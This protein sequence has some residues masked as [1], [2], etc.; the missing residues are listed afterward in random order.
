[1]TAWMKAWMTEGFERLSDSTLRPCLSLSRVLAQAGG[2]IAPFRKLH[3]IK[4]EITAAP[5]APTG[6][7]ATQPLW[8][9]W[10]AQPSARL[11]PL[12]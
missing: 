6:E 4:F 9:V 8:C 2:R 1:M 12:E 11:Q 3:N 7:V 10:T 5:D